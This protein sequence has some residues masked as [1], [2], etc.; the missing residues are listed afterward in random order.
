MEVH[1]EAYP[2]FTCYDKKSQYYDPKSSKENPRWFMVDVAYKK[3][4]KSIIS[5]SDLRAVPDLESMMVLQKG[6]RLSIQPV[7]KEHYDIIVGMSL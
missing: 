2:D 3:T 6:S 7:R 4:F 1:K 5:L